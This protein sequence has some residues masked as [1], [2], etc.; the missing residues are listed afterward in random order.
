MGERNIS[1]VRHNY[2]VIM[3]IFYVGLLLMCIYSMPNYVDNVSRMYFV[4]FFPLV[5]SLISSLVYLR[6]IGYYNNKT[7]DQKNKRR[8]IQVLLI[9]IFF[10]LHI[11]AFLTLNSWWRVHPSVGKLYLGFVLFFLITSSIVFQKKIFNYHIERIPIIIHKYYLDIFSIVI[12]STYLTFESVVMY[13]LY[14]APL[15]F[16]FNVNILN[17]YRHQK[18]YFKFFIIL[19]IVIVIIWIYFLYLLSNYNF[20]FKNLWYILNYNSASQT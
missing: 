2:F 16:L 3:L 9:S 6:L 8:T 11:I 15:P 18:Y 10:F 1:I 7:T 4:Y 17:K 12:T 14:L 20:A 13:S 5:S 19:S